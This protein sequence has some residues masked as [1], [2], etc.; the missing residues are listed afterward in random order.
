MV[1]E[2]SPSHGVNFRVHSASGNVFMFMCEFSFQGGKEFNLQH[3]AVASCAV[4]FNETQFLVI[5][6]F[7]EGLGHHRKVDRWRSFSIEACVKLSSPSQ[8][9]TV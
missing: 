3:E 5:G 2:L 8:S 9:S 6:G 7:S 4:I 1:T